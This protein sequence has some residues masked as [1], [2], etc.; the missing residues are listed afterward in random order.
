MSL[1]DSDE[2]LDN[3]DPKHEAIIVVFNATD[4]RQTLALDA[5]DTFT[6]QLHPLQK[7]SNDDIVKTSAHY[8][9]NNTVSVPA[10]TTAVFVASQH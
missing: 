5:F 4:K 1:A 10:F 9:F 6:F 7:A 8:T 3:I 2:S